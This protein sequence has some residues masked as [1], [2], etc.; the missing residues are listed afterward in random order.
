MD[1]TTATNN[2]F[3]AIICSDHGTDSHGSEEFLP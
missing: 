3:N 2:L 1:G